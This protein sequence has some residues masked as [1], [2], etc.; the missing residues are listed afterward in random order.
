VIK[1]LG[2]RVLLGAF[3]VEL[4]DDVEA[5]EEP[6]VTIGIAGVIGFPFEGAG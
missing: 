3:C 5:V 6:F 1:A 4:V 2:P